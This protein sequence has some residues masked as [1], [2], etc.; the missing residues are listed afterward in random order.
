MSQFELIAH[1]VLEFIFIFAAFFYTT[2]LKPTFLRLAIYIG[3]V[4][5]P[6][7][8][9][10]ITLPQ[11]IAICYLILSTIV[12]FIFFTRTIISAVNLCVIMVAG[13]VSDHLSIL[14]GE[15]FFAA[16]G[17]TAQIIKLIIY[18]FIFVVLIYFYKLTI[19]KENKSLNFPWIVQLF[20]MIIIII[21]IMVIY[22]NIFIPGNGEELR[23]VKIN[24]LVQMSYFISIMI[25][26]SLLLNYF[27]K[28]NSIRQKEIEFEQFLYYMKELEQVNQ[29]MHKFRHDYVNILLTMR[30]FL[31]DNNMDALKSYFHDHII[32]V[33]QQTLQHNLMF[34]QL[35]NI[36]ISELKG[37]VATKLIAAEK[38]H[39]LV[40]I[41]V[42][43]EIVEINMDIIDLARMIGI[44]LDNAIEESESVPLAKINLAILLTLQSDV[45]IVIENRT[46]LKDCNIS[47]LFQE[48][49]STKGAQRG[50]GLSTVR[51]IISNYPNAVINTSLENE[52]FVQEVV[53]GMRRVS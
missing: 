36:K 6:T 24:L 9:F 33:E 39:V 38:S 8:F 35:K 37:L 22:L 15:T 30:G 31:E 32:K 41:E 47:Q 52:W 40:N 51:N 42:P 17:D 11:W 45:V 43:D 23:F 16:I 28:R 50:L 19:H 12:T 29:D 5:L 7:A 53:I 27:K 20:L 4:V 3:G 1:G 13:I 14:I 44:L 46:E 18:S 25:L 10:L 49:Y 34:I 48:S 2:N 26:F 21:T